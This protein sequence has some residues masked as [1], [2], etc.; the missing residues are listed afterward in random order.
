MGLIRSLNRIVK[1]KNI[2]SLASNGGVAGFRLLTFMILARYLT[3]EDFGEW[4]LF[5]SASGLIEMIRYG[6]TR[7]AMVRFLSGEKEENR[8]ILIGSNWTIGLLFSLMVASLLL[9]IA[10]LFPTQIKA[11]GY[12][13][14]FYWYPV[15][16]LINLPL[17]NALTILQ[18]QQRFELI[19]LLNSISYGLFFILVGLSWIFLDLSLQQIVVAFLGVN[20]VASIISVLKGWDGLKYLKQTSRAAMQKIMGYGK[21][22]LGTLLG[23]NLLKNADTI[24]I[25]LSPLGPEAV[26]LYSIPLKLTELLEIPLRSFTATAFPRISKASIEKQPWEV[27]RLFYSYA[28]N[29]TLMFVPVSI[30]FIL[31]APFF[32]QLVGGEKYLE[33]NVTVIIFQLFAIYTL[34]APLEKFTGITLDGI[35]QPRKNFY[36]VLIMAVLN[37][38]GDLFAV[39]YLNS[40]IAVAAVTILFTLFGMGLGWVYLRHYL[41]IHVREF[42]DTVKWSVIKKSKQMRNLMN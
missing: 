8:K 14:F 2:L 36:K 34:L 12:Q 16:S 42:M 20:L 37:V 35:N 7:T 32:I 21:F 33:S 6:I 40:L 3:R 4:I 26:A 10:V 9:S 39:F 31:F 15:L 27:R 25:G 41:N 24:I 29:T 19:L 18:S 23:S 11:S 22:T 28:G 5:L 17:N 1:D 38:I 13:Y 30:I